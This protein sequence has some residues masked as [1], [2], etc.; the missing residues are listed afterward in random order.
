MFKWVKIL[1]AAGESYERIG[2][3]PLGSFTQYIFTS[4]NAIPQLICFQNTAILNLPL[5]NT[6]GVFCMEWALKACS[7]GLKAYDFLTDTSKVS[8]DRTDIS[9]LSSFQPTS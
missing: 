7:S 1:P 3:V 4:V 8:C 2:F 9:D 5:L 6:S